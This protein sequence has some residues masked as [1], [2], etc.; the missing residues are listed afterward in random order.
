MPARKAASGLAGQ[1]R[2]QTWLVSGVFCSASKKTPKEG[3]N[4]SGHL[5]ACV[6][7]IVIE[8]RRCLVGGVLQNIYIPHPIKNMQYEMRG[9]EVMWC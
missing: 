1:M 6:V 3:Q 9:G 7:K 8:E 5:Q 4:K 2:C